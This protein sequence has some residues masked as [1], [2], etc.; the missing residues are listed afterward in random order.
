MDLNPH[1]MDPMRVLN[2]A[3]SHGPIAPHILVVG[4]EPKDFGDEFEGSTGLT[5]PVRAAVEEA[6]NLIE[7][8]VAKI[9]KDIKVHCTQ[10]QIS[11]LV[12][13]N[14]EVAS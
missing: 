1:G 5:P 3:A 13:E 10:S 14:R 7:E 11:V 6:S 9:L 4:C 8:L 12:T 2:L